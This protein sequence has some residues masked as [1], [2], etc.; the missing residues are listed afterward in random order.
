VPFARTKAERV[1]AKDPRLS[2][3]ERYG[4]QEGYACT[5]R[6]AVDIAVRD[7]FLLAEDA[8]RLLSELAK[9]SVL[10]LDEVSTP[11]NVTIARQR[12]RP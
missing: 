10:P 12:C 4:S 9:S 6:R 7:R 3:E 11:E 2:V 8:Q 1:A 5:V